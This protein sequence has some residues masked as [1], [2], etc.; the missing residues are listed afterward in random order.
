MA[1]KIRNDAGHGHRP[2]H[3][4]KRAGG[5]LAVL[6]RSA[7]D[8]VANIVLIL[9]SSAV[10]SL[11]TMFVSVGLG[12]SV[13]A[14]SNSGPIHFLHNMLLG[15]AWLT[16]ITFYVILTYDVITNH[17]GAMRC[18]HED[19]MSA[20]KTFSDVD[21]MISCRLT[22]LLEERTPETMDLRHL[23]TLRLA[24]TEI[25]YRKAIIAVPTADA[26]PV[27]RARNEA[28][29]TIAGWALAERD[30]IEREMARIRNHEA[31]G[32]MDVLTNGLASATTLGS[33]RATR[34]PKVFAS[35]GNARRNRLIMNAEAA[36]RID[37]DLVDRNGARLDDLVRVHAPR[38]LEKHDAASRRAGL[39]D[40]AKAAVAM[41]EADA[42][43]DAGLAA[44]GASIE[45]AVGRLQDE[46]AQELLTEVRFLNM[47]RGDATVL[48]AIEAAR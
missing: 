36:L 21:R 28:V 11:I 34:R 6:H 10:I 7:I 15:T 3:H 29:R 18:F 2:A 24:E 31:R 39:H 40:P 26:P 33:K 19:A 8:D 14:M 4:L 32:A 17:Q 47:R 43:L 45:D 35:T 38:L 12:W 44:I 23:L 1:K 37:P 48:T 25:A 27:K 41:N 22:G 30:Q 42:A 46:S 16:P 20:A 13:T 5:P 9:V